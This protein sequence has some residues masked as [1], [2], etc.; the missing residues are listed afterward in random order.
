ML[1]LL[2][3]NNLAKHIFTW[4]CLFFC[5]VNL[6]AEDGVWD[7][8][9]YDWE[10]K[11]QLE[12]RAY[13]TKLEEAI[14]KNTHLFQIF[15][16]GEDAA[17]YEL[18]HR[19]IWVGSEKSIQSYNKLYLPVGDD[20]NVK[21]LKARVLLPNGEIFTLNDKDVQEGKDEED[22]TYRYFALDGVQKGSVVEY[23]FLT[24]TDPSY[25]GT[26]VTLQ[27]DVPVYDITFELVVPN[28]LIFKLKSY[29]QLN[30]P[31]KDTV[32]RYQNRYYIYQDSLAKFKEEPSSY[33][34]AYMG[35]VIFALERNLY[36][37]AKNIS[38]FSNSAA[39]IYA[40]IHIEVDKKMAKEFK[41]IVAESKMSLG[42]TD[43]EK[44]ALLENYLKENYF[45]S[46]VGGKELYNVSSIL[47]SR[48]MNEFGAMR[49]YHSIYNYANFTNT[50]VFTSDKSSTP[51]D[52]D[53][54]NNLMITEELLYFPEQ[55]V[56]MAP[57]DI[58]SRLGF[59]DDNL[60]NTKGLFIEGIQ[61]ADGISVG[62][63]KVRHIPPLNAKDNYSELDIDW[64]LEGDG[65]LGK[66][67][68]AHTMWGLQTG[69]LQTISKY[70]PEDEMD[71]YRKTILDSYYGESEI[72]DVEVENIEGVNFP[73]KPLVVK[74]HFNDEVYTEP[75]STST[76][77]KV[78]MIIG[79][80]SE[81]Y[82]TEGE[83]KLPVHHGFPKWYNRKIK[84]TVP[85]GYVLKNLSSLVM[86]VKSDEDEPLMGFVSNYT[87]KNNVLEIE[88]NEWYEKGDYPATEFEKYREVINAAADFNKK[89]VVLEKQ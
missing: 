71:N 9:A 37:G 6:A 85:E 5:S 29:N 51:F 76:I 63:E 2:K 36:S 17:M 83:R 23:L 87:Y 69:Y 57:T 60:R 40:N 7:I 33:S 15:Y 31:E 8:Q 89:Y 68:V 14:I 32:L 27:R 28:N 34:R 81:M 59:F 1:N 39:N 49:L 73:T 44:I 24:K 4:F 80:Q 75:S 22:N 35:Y 56:Y 84:I 66:I 41:K 52:P 62:L 64:Q 42:K 11:P 46:N 25:M 88:I 65:D 20:E 67:N 58:T 21:I 55:D 82:L 72:K 18:L 77:V 43:R 61:S 16:E 12:N 79:P 48:A 50:I 3:T 70:V 86:N 19:K 13:I 30:Q 10:E 74:A 53:F 26:R 38:S 45:V 54:E 78:G 47:Q